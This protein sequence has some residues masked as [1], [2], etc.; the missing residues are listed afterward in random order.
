MANVTVD[1]KEVFDVFMTMSEHE[2]RILRGW[3]QNPL[4]SDPTNENGVE[5][6]LRKKIFDALVAQGVR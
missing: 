4:G 3:V 5:A 1:R 2:A 6:N